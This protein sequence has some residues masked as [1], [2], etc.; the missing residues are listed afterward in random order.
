MLNELTPIGAQTMC[1]IAMR[2][3][4]DALTHMRHVQE[5]AQAQEHDTQGVEG[6]LGNAA[7]HLRVATEWLVESRCAVPTVGV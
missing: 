4:E 5:W 3:I 2:Q 6:A 1:L 7:L